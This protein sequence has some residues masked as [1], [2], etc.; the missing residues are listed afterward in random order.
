[1]KN[2]AII[3]M[4]ML[5]LTL[6]LYFVPCLCKTNNIH[7][8]IFY[9]VWYDEG[10]G[11]RHWNSSEL[12]T[13]IDK[14]LLGF[15]N[16]QD[17]YII[18]KHL[19]W[20]EQLQI[21]FLIISWWGPK[22]YEDNATKLL[23][24]QIANSDYKPELAIMIEPFNETGTYNY[25]EIYNYIYN[26]YVAAYPQIYMKLYGKPLLCLYNA[27]NLTKNGKMPLDNRFEIRIVGHESYANWL[28]YG[29]YEMKSWENEL[30][31]DGQIS[32]MPRYDDTH[33][34][35]PGAQKDPTYKEGYYDQQ[36]SKVLKLARE[37]KVNYVT[38]ATWNEYHERTQ[39]E[40]CW[41]KTSYKKNDPFY[42]FKKTKDYIK[43][44][45]G[46]IPQPIQPEIIAAI[47]V[48]AAGTTALLKLV[49]RRS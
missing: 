12:T 18:Q 21:D 22:S 10:L 28:F 19:E 35:S 46:T 33:F 1:M 20:F 4:A 30:V 48:A 3:L 9:Y 44:L 13:V 42:I 29:S 34:R 49:S 43:Q 26:E 32:V 31:M 27:E 25:T 24:Q 41:D 8:G 14:P 38:I 16:S 36:W 5:I 11:N 40:P 45:K 23:F 6:I 17:T 47:A 2:Q 7:V 15:Y 37:G 39:I